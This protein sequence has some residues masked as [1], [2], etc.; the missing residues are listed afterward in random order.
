MSDAARTSP[1]P[2]TSPTPTGAIAPTPAPPYVAVVFTSLRAVGV[3]SDSDG[4][5]AAAARMDDLASQQPGYLGI[6]SARDGETG[7]GITVSYW[8]DEAA[9][10]AWRGV[11]EHLEAQRRGRRSGISTTA[12]GSPPSPATTAT[13]PHAP[14]PTPPA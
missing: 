14:D 9:A 13:P 4:Y 6:E 1:Q 8:A 11:A 5:A 10:H 7:L 2:V 3:E 12:S